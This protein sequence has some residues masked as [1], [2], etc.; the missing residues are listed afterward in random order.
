MGRKLKKAVFA[1]IFLTSVV[2]VS[3][4]LAETATP[5]ELGVE[6]TG[7]LPSNPFYF[8]KEWGRGLRRTLTVSD[9]K[10]AQL[11]L[12]FL[13][14]RAA[15][16]MKLE[17]ITPENISAFARGVA[18]YGEGASELKNKLVLLRGNA[19]ATRLVDPLL[20]KAL[21]HQDILVGLFNKFGETEGAAEFY[22]SIDTA[23]DALTEVVAAIPGNLT[24]SKK[25]RDAFESAVAAGKNEAK[26]LM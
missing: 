22:L 9:F 4:I 16:I 11:A 20:D 18:N 12:E 13:N 7:I 6:N 15:E 8:F 25:F 21:K 1:L 17:E 19:S 3:P 26:E 2:P 14:E 5:S 10:K 23:L 24:D